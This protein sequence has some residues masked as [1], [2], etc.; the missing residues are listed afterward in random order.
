[1][2]REQ[3]SEHAA[4]LGLQT[5]A[6]GAVRSNI[7]TEGID[8]ISLIGKEVKVGQA[9]LRFYAPRDPCYKMDAIC[10]GLRE[11]MMNSKQGVLAEVVRSGT[12]TVGDAITV[13]KVASEHG[14]S[15]SPNA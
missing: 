10:Q 1:M 6:P 15:G 7:E 4:T 9:V 14:P 8:L 12:I 5:I 3:I 2:E 13:S 11:L